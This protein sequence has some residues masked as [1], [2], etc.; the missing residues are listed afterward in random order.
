MNSVDASAIGEHV[1][2]G[3]HVNSIEAVLNGSAD[4]ASVDHSVWDARTGVDP[5]LEHLRVLATTDDWPA[6]PISIRTT[7]PDEV[8]TRLGDA[9]MSL[10]DVAPVHPSD[11]YFMLTEAE[12]H[13]TWP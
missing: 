6:P 8:R 13:P 7:L 9:I 4:I 2:T 10:P 1:L 3:G 5:R 11:Y 12:E